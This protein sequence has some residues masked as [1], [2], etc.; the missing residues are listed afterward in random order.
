MEGNSTYKDASNNE[1]SYSAL[2]FEI[3][4][5]EG[6]TTINVYITGATDNSNTYRKYYEV[7]GQFSDLFE[8]VSDIYAENNI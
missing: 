2:V 7:K 3:S 5:T 4:S 1:Y 8:Y 6:E